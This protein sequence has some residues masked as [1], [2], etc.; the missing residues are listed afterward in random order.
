MKNLDSRC[1]VRRT[2]YFCAAQQ[3]RIPMVHGRFV[4][5]SKKC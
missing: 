1:V 3:D 4:E 5:S 2:E